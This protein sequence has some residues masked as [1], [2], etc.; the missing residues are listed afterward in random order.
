MKLKVLL[1]TGVL[2]EEEVRKVSLEAED[3][4]M[5]LLPRHIDM[6]TSVAP[7]ILSFEGPRGEE[8]VALARIARRSGFDHLDGDGPVDGSL[9]GVVDHAHSPL[10]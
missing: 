3:G 10:P 8:F 2:V 4:E 5:T 9:P 6:T 1:P 7:G